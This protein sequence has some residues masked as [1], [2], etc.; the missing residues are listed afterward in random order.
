MS[1]SFKQ[2]FSFEKR[3][4]EASRMR[5]LY[6]DRVPIICEKY[7]KQELPIIQKKKYLVPYEITISQFISVIRKRL[8]LRSEL[9][10]LLSVEGFVPSSTMTIGELYNEHK[11]ADGFLYIEYFQEN[12]FGSGNQRFPEPLLL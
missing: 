2:Q 7:K 1:I 11:H 3:F 6:P 4:F 8:S 9:S 5:N 10:I 12:T